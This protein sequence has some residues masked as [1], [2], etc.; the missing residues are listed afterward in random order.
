MRGL[1]P[2]GAWEGGAQP[3]SSEDVGR[4]GIGASLRPLPSR[5]R[6]RPVLRAA[7]VTVSLLSSLSRVLGPAL[8]CPGQL[9][10]SGQAGRPHTVYGSAFLC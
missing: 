2:P 3:W 10:C 5:G 6:K 8:P 1:R 7:L 4:A 9:T